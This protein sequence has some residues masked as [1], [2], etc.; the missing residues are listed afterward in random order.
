[1][2]NIYLNIFKLI[3]FYQ[4]IQIYHNSIPPYLIL[5]PNR[6]VNSTD[7][8][9]IHSPLTVHNVIIYTR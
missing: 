1:M 9:Q 8:S 3:I 4:I 7:F 2:C 6:I 5:H